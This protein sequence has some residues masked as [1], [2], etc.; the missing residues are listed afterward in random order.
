MQD[1]KHKDITGKIIGCAMRVHSFLGAGFRE[2]IYQ[3]ALAIEF[4]REGLI[5]KREVEMPIYYRLT[6]FRIC[7]GYVYLQG[8]CLSKDS[9][10]FRPKPCLHL[11][12]AR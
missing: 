12:L 3:R 4:Q 11:I 7:K 2:V 9:L 6:A 10:R 1:L 8:L 5:F